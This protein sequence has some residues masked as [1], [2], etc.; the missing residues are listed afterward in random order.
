[1]SYGRIRGRERVED[2]RDGEMDIEI[3]YTTN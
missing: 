3:M 1:M 2:K